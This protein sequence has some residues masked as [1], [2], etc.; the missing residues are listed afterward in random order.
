[1]TYKTMTQRLETAVVVPTVSEKVANYISVLR[2]PSNSGIMS[3]DSNLKTYVFEPEVIESIYSLADEFESENFIASQ[4]LRSL[5]GLLMTNN[6][7]RCNKDRYVTVKS[8]Y[9]LCDGH[10]YEK[11][12]V[13]NGIFPESLRLKINAVYPYD[14]ISFTGRGIE[15]KLIRNFISDD[16]RLYSVTNAEDKCLFM[17]P[18]Y[19]HVSSFAPSK[20]NYYKLFGTNS[21]TSSIDPE[22][23][24]KLRNNIPLTEYD[25]DT[26]KF[27]LD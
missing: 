17:N 26:A 7:A 27:E 16:V 25:R 11:R 12:E 21:A 13:T 22:I 15:G 3:W 9:E 14:K 6:L 24:H 23:L 2:S 1:M 8:K 10:Q 18:Y 4:E 20:V 19:A 5:L